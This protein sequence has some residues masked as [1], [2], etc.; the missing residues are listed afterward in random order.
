MELLKGLCSLKPVGAVALGDGSAISHYFI[1][2]KAGHSVLISLEI[3]RSAPLKS[4]LLLEARL[5]ITICP[6]QLYLP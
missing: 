3:L 2:I 6:V 1:Q 4:I 5:F